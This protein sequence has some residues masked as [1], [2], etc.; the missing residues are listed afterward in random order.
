MNTLA[1]LMRMEIHM[2]P[3]YPWIFLEIT[4]K[5]RTE[6]WIEDWKQA[7]KFQ[8]QQHQVKW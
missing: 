2:Y 3:I 6:F 4:T 7:V 1:D 5:Y 8:E